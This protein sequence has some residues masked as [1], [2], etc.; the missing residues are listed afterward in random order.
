MS[1]K[2]IL[3]VDADS[4]SLNYLVHLVRK[5]GYSA[6]GA[7]SGEEGL[8]KN[9]TNEIQGGCQRYDQDCK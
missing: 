1:D 2:S 8:T 3:V 4:V 7:D 6:A 5:Q 9:D